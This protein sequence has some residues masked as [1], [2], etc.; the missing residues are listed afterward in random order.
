MEQP[1]LMGC[2]SL[3]ADSYETITQL[4]ISKGSN[5]VSQNGL[6]VRPSRSGVKGILQRI[7]KCAQT[8]GCGV[9]MWKEVSVPGGLALPLDIAALQLGEDIGYIALEVGAIA[10]SEV[11]T[12]ISEPCPACRPPCLD[13]IRACF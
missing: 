2:S 9:A 10:K 5:Q 6:E 7:E 1:P 12:L 3:H 4:L 13:V 11:N 8:V